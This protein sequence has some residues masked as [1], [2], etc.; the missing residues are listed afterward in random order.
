MFNFDPLEFFYGKMLIKPETLFNKTVINAA[1]G[2][3]VPH[4]FHECPYC[5]SKHICKNGKTKQGKQRYICITCRK[6]FSQA[7]GSPF[8]YSK[9]PGEMW[10]K[11][12]Q[13]MKENLTLREICKFLGI[14]LSTSFYWRHKILSVLGT[15]SSDSCFSGSAE[16]H[17]LK[18]KENFKGNHSG[19]PLPPK[20]RGSVMILSS[21]DSNDNIFIKA[22]AKNEI[23]REVLDKFLTPVVKNCTIIG[24]P[25]RFLY[26]AFARDN[27]LGLYMKGSSTYSAGYV[28]YGK[29][30][31]QSLDF[32]RFLCAFS[33][34]A[35]KYLSNYINLF[36]I[37][38][39]N[40]K[41]IAEN[42]LI[43]RFIKGKGQL[44][45]SDFAKVQ[46]V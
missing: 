23:T 9:K 35:S 2:N 39:K 7:T 8:M 31:K 36:I 17:E 32:K 27:N 26:V 21:N 41:S 20:A 33:G 42:L 29:S 24:S 10:I 19:N 43:D 6:S 3:M 11:Y 18:I 30:Q 45:V 12:I 13:C 25:R 28:S 46:F 5:D 37:I 15:Q 4:I 1:L 38:Y 16:I 22:A 14:S 40:S 44:K 34:V